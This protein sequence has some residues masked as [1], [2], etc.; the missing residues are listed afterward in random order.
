MIKEPQIPLFDLIMS[1]STAMD[2]VSTAVVNH[3]KQV[4]YIALSIGAEL[5]LPR[6]QQNQLVLAGALHDIGA[7]SLKDRLDTLQFEIENP[8]EHTELGYLLLE[9]FEPLSNVAALVRFHHIPWS[10]GAGAEFEGKPVAIDSHLLHLADRVAVLV[11]KRQEVLGQVKRVCERVVERSGAMFV[12]EQVD[13][14]MSLATKEYFWLDVV[15]PSIGS[16]LSKRVRLATIELDMEGLLGLARLFSQI[17][18][19]RSRFTATHSSGVAASAESLAR[20]VGFSE[21]ECQMMKIAGHLHDLGKLAVPAEILEKPAKLTEE[22]FNLIK[23]HTF[24]TYSILETIS[25]LDVINAWASFH[26]E[27]LDGKGYPFHH[28][29]D[30]LS[31]GSRIMAV[32]DVFTAITEDRPYRKGMTSDRALEVLQRMADNSA[33]D[34]SIISLLRLHFDEVS[35]FRKAAQ[36]AAVEEYQ[37]FLLPRG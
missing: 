16:I 33:L 4:A 13:A 6:E 5:G 28:K 3:H 30:D 14:F 23:S 24:Y 21:R 12:P 27:R 18:D 11:N 32:A 34:S 15:S 8:H 9:T 35:S 19:F 7:F 10:E 1:L 22:E 17:I 29:G 36:S 25:D 37:Q 31:L 20:F 2:L 26:H